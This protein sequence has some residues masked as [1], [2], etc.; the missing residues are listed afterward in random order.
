MPANLGGGILL[1]SSH[2]LLIPTIVFSIL[3]WIPYVAGQATLVAIF[4]TAYHTCRAFNACPSFLPLQSATQLDYI[5]ALSFIIVDIL[6][7][8]TI[9]VNY[10]FLAEGGY[11]RALGKKLPVGF[12]EREIFATTTIYQLLMG[13]VIFTV[14][15]FGSNTN[16]SLM[17]GVLVILAS[18]VSI[19]LKVVFVNGMKAMLV[20][21][22]RIAYLV[23][24]IV[25]IFVSLVFFPYEGDWYDWAHLGWHV[26]VFIGEWLFVIGVTRRPGYVEKDIQEFLD[27]K[28]TNT[29]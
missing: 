11:A 19:L 29:V 17:M 2:V 6:L 28:R 10:V 12:V 21:Q 7:L 5:W 1:I 13:F 24:G 4:S 16:N 22:F 8:C 18:T 9:V 15:A 23:T 20:S 27:S 14:I 26:F 3:C 25:F